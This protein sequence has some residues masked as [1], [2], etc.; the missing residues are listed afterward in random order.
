MRLLVASDLHKEFPKQQIPDPPAADTYDVVILAGDIA[1]DNQGITWASRKFPDKQVLYVPGNHEYYKQNI[2]NSKQRMIEAAN[3]L[4]NVGLL[5]PGFTEL[6]GI[7]F[8]GATMW[9][10]LNLEGYEPLRDDVVEGA[11]SDF[12]VI[13]DAPGFPFTAHQMRKLFREEYEFLTSELAHNTCDKVVVITH[14]VPTQQCVHER[15][16]GSFL[17]PYFTNDLDH[18][19]EQYKP[20]LWIAGHTHDRYDVQHPSGTRIVIN[21]HGYPGENKEPWEWKVVEV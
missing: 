8:I 1:Y 14:F 13:Y 9:S 21:P 20:A 16:V 19:M 11:I 12:R 4:P 2:H 15:F 17:N 18:V 6:G 5:N 10:D 3:A 7:K